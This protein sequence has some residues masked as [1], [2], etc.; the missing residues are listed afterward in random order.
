VWLPLL[1]ML[2]L[3]IPCLELVASLAGTTK[4]VR[5]YCRRVAGAVVDVAVAHSM[6]GIGGFF[7]WYRQSNAETLLPWQPETSASSAKG[8]RN[9]RRQ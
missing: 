5:K 6:S 7:G 4:A 8:L 1:S 3:Q 2:L 9:W